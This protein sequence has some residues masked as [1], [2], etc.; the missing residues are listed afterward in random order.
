[1]RQSKKDPATKEWE[2]LLSC[3]RRRGADAAADYVIE[4]IQSG[5]YP[6]YYSQKF[7]EYL[8]KREKYIT[9]GKILKALKEAGVEHSLIDKLRGWQLWSMGKKEAAISYAIKSARRWLAPFLFY[10]V[11]EF[12]SKKG[13][14]EKSD[15]YFNIAS[16]LAK[17]EENKHNN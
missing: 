14:R 9:A 8:L 3:V 10:Q 12:Y 2:K 11:S 5:R 7:T 4:L 13:D 1:M 15:Y 16:S 17:Q 6:L